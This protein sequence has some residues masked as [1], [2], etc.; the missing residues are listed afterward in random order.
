MTPSDNSIVWEDPP[1][2]PPGT[3]LWMGPFVEELRAHPGKW[4]TDRQLRADR[5]SD[6]GPSEEAGCRRTG[7]PRGRHEALPRLGTVAR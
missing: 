3:K 7:L 6:R 1:P 2:P 5:P 4:A